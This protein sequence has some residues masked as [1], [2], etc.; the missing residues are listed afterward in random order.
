MK[1][2]TAMVLRKIEP[3]KHKK[4]QS[5]YLR[6]TSGTVDK[7]NNTCLWWDKEAAQDAARDTDWTAQPVAIVLMPC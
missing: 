3:D 5:V 1:I 7:F 2:G 6:P 4:Q